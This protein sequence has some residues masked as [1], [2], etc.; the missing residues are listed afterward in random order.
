MRA[1]SCCISIWFCMRMA[2][3][4]IFDANSIM[5]AF[6]PPDSLR[7]TESIIGDATSDHVVLLQRMRGRSRRTGQPFE[8]SILEL[9]SFRDGKLIGI[10]PY[11]WDTAA[12]LAIL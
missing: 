10:K 3:T 8:M 7:F 9:Y 2:P 5:V 11:Y 4:I 12:L 6:L 1:L